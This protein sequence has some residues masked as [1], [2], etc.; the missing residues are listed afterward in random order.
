MSFQLILVDPNAALCDAWREAF[1]DL[2]RVEVVTGRFQSVDEFDC[3]VSPANSFGLMDG[4]VDA[5]II[6]FFGGQLMID[7][8]QHIINHYLGEQPIG[9]CF[10]IGTGHAQHPWLAHTPTMRIPTDIAHTDNVYMATWALLR[11]VHHHNLSDK[12]KIER[13]LC[14]GLGTGTGHVQPKEAARQM[15]LAYRN[16]LNPPKYIDWGFAQRR[17]IEVRYG[18]NRPLNAPPGE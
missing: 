18:G 4:G 17:E 11:A 7:V 1:A 16:Y 3:M 2:S 9:S 15:S 5:A 13:V 8:Q 10:I 12:L 14:P 6:N